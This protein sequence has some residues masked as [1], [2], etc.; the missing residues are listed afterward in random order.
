MKALLSIAVVAVVLMFTLNT[1]PAFAGEAKVPADIVITPPSGD[2]PQEHAKFSGIWYATWY[3]VRTRA[4]MTDHAV[5]VES[6]NGDT[7]TVTYVL[8][9]EPQWQIS[10]MRITLQGSFLSDGSLKLS[11]PSGASAVYSMDKKGRLTGTFFSTSGQ[12]TASMEKIR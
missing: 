3:G 6:I 10:A 8:G 1:L 2:T 11:F 4:M 7:A 12:L 9:A 5:V